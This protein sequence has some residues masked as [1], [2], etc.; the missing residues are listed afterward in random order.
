MEKNRRAVIFANGESTSN[1]RLSDEINK[2]HLLIAADGGLHHFREMGILPHVL[3]GDFDSLQP[4]QLSELE[5][6]DIT[7]IRYP[8]RKDETDLEL[9]LQYAKQ[10]GVNEAIVFY[11]LGSRWDMTITNMLL[12][13]LEMFH[14][15]DIHII[16]GLQE[17]SLLRSGSTLHISGRAGDT[18]SLIPLGGNAM[19]INSYGLEYSLNDDTLRLGSSRGVS[20]VL[21]EDTA[22]V[23]L[24]D[25]FLL[26]I[27]IKQP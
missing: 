25:G 10:K 6:K 21:Q 7:I 17:I 24:T 12:P 9:A 14:D 23:Q 18:I 16:D 22:S 11:A 26:C 20:N 19:G 1:E 27:H 3:I 5:G 2:A 13:T 4:N 15:L 8:S